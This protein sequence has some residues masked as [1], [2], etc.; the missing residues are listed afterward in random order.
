MLTCRQFRIHTSS[1]VDVYIAASSNPI[2]EHCSAMRFAAYPTALRHPTSTTISDLTDPAHYVRASY[3]ISYIASSLG[4][5]LIILLPHRA[6]R[7][8][9]TIWPCKTSPMS[10][11]PHHRTGLSSP[12]MPQFR[13]N[14]GLCLSWKTW[15]SRCEVYFLCGSAFWNPSAY[16]HLSSWENIVYRNYPC[17]Q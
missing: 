16:P 4:P 7:P 6:Q 5:I 13:T 14:S 17:E 2:I 12:R 15:T 3:H 8:M 10:V 1:Q 11:L 9:P